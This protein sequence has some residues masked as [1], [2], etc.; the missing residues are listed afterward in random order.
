MEEAKLVDYAVHMCEIG[1]GRTKEQLLEVVKSIIDKDGRPNPFQHSKPGRKWWRLFKRRHPELSLR[2]AEHLQ[3]ARARC[4]TPEA[5]QAWFIEF[6]QFL[7]I[8]GLDGKPERI[9]NTDESGFPLFPNSG[10][11]ISLRSSKSVHNNYYW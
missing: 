3:L 11:V 2:K 5:L 7:S 6:Q 4:C 9:W 8:H 10:K 1:Y